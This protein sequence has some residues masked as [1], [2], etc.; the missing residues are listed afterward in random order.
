VLTGYNEAF[1]IDA[2]TK[3]KLLAQ[4]PKSSEILKPILRGKDIKRYCDDFADLW[5][6]NSHNGY[7]DTPKINIDDYPAVKQHLD[8]YWD[9]IAKRYDKGDTP[10]NLRNCAYVDEFVQDNIFYPDIAPYLSMV[11]C[12]KI[13]VTNTGYFL[14]TANRYIL[15]VIN[16]VLM[17]FYYKLISVQLGSSGMRAFTIYIEK[18]PIPKLSTTEQQPFIDAADTMLTLNQNLQEITSKFTRSLQR[19]F[20][21]LAKLPKALQTWYNLDYKEFT[22]QLAKK[23]IKLSLSQEAEWEEY[24]LA[25]QAKALALKNQIDTTDKKIDHMVYELYGLTADEIKIVEDSTQ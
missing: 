2:T 23:K 11:L 19:K 22:G 16:S 3:D 18:L 7:K 14:N 12:N 1:I 6:I 17:N 9:K 24:F 13:Y 5:L 4:D 10:Y 15:S 25:E 8:Q 21:S 20:E